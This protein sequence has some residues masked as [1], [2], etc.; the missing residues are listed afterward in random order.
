MQDVHDAAAPDLQEARLREELGERPYALSRAQRLV[1]AVDHRVLPVR[2]QVD[3]VEGPEDVRGAAYL[4]HLD[5][6]SVAVV[7]REH[8]H[9]A[10]RLAREAHGEVLPLAR[11]RDGVRD[12]HVDHA[13]GPVR[14]VAQH[15]GH[16]LAGAERGAGVRVV[17][18]VVGAH[19]DGDP[20]LGDNRGVVLVHDDH[21]RQRRH[22]AAVEGE[23]APPVKEVLVVLGRDPEEVLVE[24]RGEELRV[25][26]PEMMHELVRE[27][28]RRAPPALILHADHPR[29]LVSSP[30]PEPRRRPR[31]TPGRRG[32]PGRPRARAPAHGRRAGRPRAG[33]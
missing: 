33:A 17:E 10:V 6:R 31:A 27:H 19:H 29:L 21:V 13:E 3:H 16:A 4:A 1:E 18:P 11:E 9:V 8:A 7:A 14:A 22:Y 23:G 28:L 26:A 20:A 15:E 24:R 5:A 2:L 25:V 32:A 30:C 12:V